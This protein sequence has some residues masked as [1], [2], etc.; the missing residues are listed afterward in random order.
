MGGRV[1]IP[2]Q[3]TLFLTLGLKGEVGGVGIPTPSILIPHPEVEGGRGGGV[4]I[5]IPS[6]LVL[7]LG[8]K[9]VG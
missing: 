8:F 9:G 6:T 3:S 5:P 2:S 7:S 4:G 1:G